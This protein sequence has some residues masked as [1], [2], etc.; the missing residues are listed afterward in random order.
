MEKERIK[1]LKKRGVRVGEVESAGKE[2]REMLWERIKGRELQR[3]RLEREKGILE[4]RYNNC[5]ML[6]REDVLPEYLDKGKKE[7]KWRKVARYRLGNE[8]RGGRY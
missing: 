7:K 6:I 3:Q 5:Y 4:S 2:E 1:F 8:M